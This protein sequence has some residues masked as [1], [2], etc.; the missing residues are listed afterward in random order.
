MR[1]AFKVKVTIK[2]ICCVCVCARALSLFLPFQVKKIY[3]HRASHD[4]SCNKNH[5]C[6]YGCLTIQQH[7]HLILVQK[8]YHLQKQTCLRLH[9]QLNFK[10][11][12]NQWKQTVRKLIE[13][14][15]VRRYW[16]WNQLSFLQA[17]N[18]QFIC[19]NI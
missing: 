19:I 12:I 10:Q 13:H 14:I 8:R 18:W 4:S 3:T 2:T 17:F 6:L 5:L 11:E 9:E 1:K 16:R 15:R 7:L